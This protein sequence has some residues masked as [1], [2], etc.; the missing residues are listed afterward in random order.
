MTVSGYGWLRLVQ[1]VK[2]GPRPSRVECRVVPAVH[3]VLLSPLAALAGL[4]QPPFLTVSQ[5]P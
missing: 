4:Q 3:R 2:V 5:M 1:G